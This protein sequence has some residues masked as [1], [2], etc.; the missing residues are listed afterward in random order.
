[1]LFGI[2]GSTEGDN[3]AFGFDFFD[4]SGELLAAIIFDT[5]AVDFGVW[6]D[7]SVTST[8]TGELFTPGL[9]NILSISIDL[10]ANQWSADLEGEILF[11]DISFTASTAVRDLG[12]IGVEWQIADV[13]APGDNWMLF[14]DISLTAIDEL[15][16]TIVP[17]DTFRITSVKI[18]PAG[19]IMLEWP[20]ISG[21]RYQIQHSQ[22]GLLWEADSASEMIAEE[23]AST[24]T[25]VAQRPTNTLR[26]YRVAWLESAQ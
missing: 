19:G 18:A 7:D 21:I 13:A 8:F 20:A 25:Y 2:N 14:K 23:S 12:G 10:K 9:L 22:D 5:S 3:D 11:T 16:P 24:L 1:V 17:D 26:L 15:P 6:I 4:G